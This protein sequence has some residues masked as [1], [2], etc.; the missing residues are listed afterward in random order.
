MTTLAEKAK[1]AIAEN[2]ATQSVLQEPWHAHYA[3]ILNA[4]TVLA[5]CMNEANNALNLIEQS[6]EA[7]KTGK[8]WTAQFQNEALEPLRGLT[9]QDIS[10]ATLNQRL[11]DC[12]P[13]AE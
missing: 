9:T 11:L 12:L 4:K 6:T 2:Q 5:Q 3:V 8:F 10:L 1:Q 13:P 7:N